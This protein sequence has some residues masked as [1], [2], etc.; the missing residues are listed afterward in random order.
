MKTLSTALTALVLITAMPAEA[1]TV[2]C[3]QSERFGSH[4]VLVGDSE[5]KVRQAAGQP[6]VERQLET[7]QG[8]AAGIRLDYYR[9]AATVQVYVQ[10]G[11]VTRICRV[12]D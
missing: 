7:R 4:L 12:R 2:R 10:A 1:N 9:P 8:G 11:I 6:A 3:G 5:R